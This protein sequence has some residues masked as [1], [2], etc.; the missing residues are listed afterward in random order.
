VFLTD[1]SRIRGLSMRYDLGEIMG[2]DAYGEVVITWL[3]DSPRC[4][5]DFGP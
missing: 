3:Y 5:H 4:V 2:F 1:L